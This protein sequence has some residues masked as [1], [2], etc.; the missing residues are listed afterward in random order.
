MDHWLQLKRVTGTRGEGMTVETCGVAFNDLSLRNTSDFGDFS[1]YH[2]HI[3]SIRL[4]YRSDQIGT[5]IAIDE[6]LHDGA[7]AA[8]TG[9]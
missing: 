3:G 1:F 5:V 2:L 4:F 7:D 8:D 9:T 6:D